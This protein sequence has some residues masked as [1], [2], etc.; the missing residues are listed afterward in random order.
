MALLRRN[1]DMT[2]T[3]MEDGTFVVDPSTQAI[4]YLDTLAG[5]VWTA[6]A[7][8]MSAA[9][10]ETLLLDAFPDRP[11]EIV[12]ADLAT[13]LRTMIERGLLLTAPG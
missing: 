10:L 9:D 6:L 11:R 13:L 12:S 4:F 1:P 3:A 8:P 2:V 5:G 7:E